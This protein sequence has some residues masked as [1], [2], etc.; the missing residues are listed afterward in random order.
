MFF[1]IFY[2]NTQV[3]ID[4]LAESPIT[5]GI[6]FFS[7]LPLSAFSDF[8]CNAMYCFYNKKKDYFNFKKANERKAMFDPFDSDI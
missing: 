5:S 6:T 8:F 3:P 7:S 2:L 1:S 4:L